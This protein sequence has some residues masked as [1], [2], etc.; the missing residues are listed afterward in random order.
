MNYIIRF[1]KREELYHHG[2]LGQKWGQRNGPP[3]PIAPSNH[4]ASEKKKGY[5]KS[6][7]GYSDTKGTV[8]HYSPIFAQAEDVYFKERESRVFP[9]GRKI[10]PAIGEVISDFER[11]GT[12]THHGQTLIYRTEKSSGALRSGAFVYSSSF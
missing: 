2:I 5:Y 7:K 10:Y 1:L 11:A 9:D 3:Y 8:H 12:G 6:I 4:S